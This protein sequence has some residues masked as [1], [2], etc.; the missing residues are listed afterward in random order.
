MQ[1]KQPYKYGL[2]YDIK[3]KMIAQIIISKNNI[4]HNIKQFKGILPKHVKI[5]AVVKANAYGHGQNEV[6]VILENHVDY[7]QVDDLAELEKLRE[8]T[9]KP[10]LV[11]GYVKNEE[12]EQLV[13]L[14]GIP[15]IYDL[16]RLK[17][18]EKIGKRDDKKIKVHIKIDACLGR[19]G[20]L[21]KNVPDF[22][23][24]AKKLKYIEIEGIYA[25]FA[26]I[27]DT[28][29]FTHSQKQIDI[30]KKAV[31]IFE[32]NG[33]K[34]LMKHM[35]P[36]SGILVHEPKNK[37]FDMVRI[38]MGLH[39]LWPSKDLE[40]KYKNKIS[41]RSA[42]TWKTCIAQV[43]DVPRGFNIGYGLTYKTP[44][45]KK[46]AVIPQGYGDGYNRLLS[47]N[48]DVL[49]HGKRC[50]IIGRVAMNMFVVDVSH[51]EGVKVEEEVVLLGSQKDEEVT[52]EELATKTNTINYEVVSRIN[53]LIPRKVV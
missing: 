37:Y 48:G 38:G 32:K 34:K 53:P 46:I 6:A 30:F 50:P 3:T 1:Y 10:V 22:I 9:Q 44:S 19:Q 31:G 28:S 43:K 41:L 7:F 11:F 27:K 36:T 24:E 21:L 18:L 52:A 17:L 26:N 40:N 8:K 51:V 15:G 45:E 2:F 5:S 20:I 42:M 16:R 47:N 12:L 23:K 29:D 33:Y 13:K 4:L 39:G 14:K 25:H 49:I 35:S